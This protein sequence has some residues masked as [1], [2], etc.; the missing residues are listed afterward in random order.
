MIAKV[1]SE[2]CRRY[3]NFV[4]CKKYSKSA[5]SS[6]LKVLLENMK[7]IF[8]GVAIK[9]YKKLVRFIGKH[10]KNSNQ[11]HCRFKVTCYS[12]NIKRKMFENSLKNFLKK[13]HTYKK[14]LPSMRNGLKWIFY[15][16]SNFKVN[17]FVAQMRLTKKW[18]VF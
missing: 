11:W 6:A 9:F 18:Y 16:L 7:F 14:C 8:F 1:F 5:I 15:I 17:V 12:Y 4:F 2:K 3:F 13:S 10:L